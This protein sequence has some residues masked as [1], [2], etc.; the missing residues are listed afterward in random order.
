MSKRRADSNRSY[1][2]WNA[3]I[4]R[5]RRRDQQVGSGQNIEKQNIESQNIESKIAIEVAEIEVAKYHTKIIEVTKH[6]RQVVE[7]AKDK[8]RPG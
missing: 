3:W 7:H 1:H 2:D 6:Q 4:R 8:V 5:W